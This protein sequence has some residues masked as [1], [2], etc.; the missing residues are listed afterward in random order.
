MSRTE[1]IEHLEDLALE[2]RVFVDGF[3]HYIRLGDGVSEAQPGK[4]FGGYCHGLLPSDHSEIYEAREIRL[5]IGEGGVQACFRAGMEADL[6]ARKGKF[7]RNPVPHH[8]C[9]DDG[10]ALHVLSTHTLPPF[11][12]WKAAVEK[13]FMYR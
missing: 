11:G 13:S 2:R 12:I 10:D 4:K 8:S 6:V 7:L 3:N 9:P 1:G 5:D